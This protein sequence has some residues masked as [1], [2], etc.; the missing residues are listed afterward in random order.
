MLLLII[1]HIRKFK[2][3]S[4]LWLSGGYNCMVH[5]PHVKSITISTFVALHYCVT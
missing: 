4:S 3:K 5:C 1:Y 2:F